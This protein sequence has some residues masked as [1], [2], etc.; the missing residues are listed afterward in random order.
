MTA[1]DASREERAFL[2][3]GGAGA[4]RE[5]ALAQVLF[6]LAQTRSVLNAYRPKRDKTIT[7]TSRTR[8]MSDFL[9]GTVFFGFRENTPRLDWYVSG[10]SRIGWEDVPDLGCRDEDEEYEAVLRRLRKAGINPVVIDL[11]AACWP[12]GHLVRVIVPEM[13]LA[14]VAANPYLGH[15]RYYELPRNLGLADRRLAFGDLNPDPIPFP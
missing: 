14:C 8:E 5:R 2:G 13:T 15:P 1:L 11:Q 3:A 10:G 4:S 7:A 12:G 6:E 9:D